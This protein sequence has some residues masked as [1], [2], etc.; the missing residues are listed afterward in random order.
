MNKKGKKKFPLLLVFLALVM[1]IF[2]GGFIALNLPKEVDLGQTSDPEDNLPNPPP[3]EPEYVDITISSVGDILIHNT[4]Y[5]AAYEPATKSYDFRSQFQ[6]VKPYLEKA[7]ITIANLETTLAGPE[8]G[9]SGYPKFNSPDSIIDALK[10]A[11]VDIITA[12]NNHRMDMGISGFY[13]T[14]KIVKDK[15]LDI[16]GVKPKN[17]EKT[18]MLRNVK[19]VN[20]AFLNFSYAYPLG[21]GSLSINGLILPVNMRNLIDIFNPED[22]EESIK[23]LG[24]K[25]TGAREDGAELIVVCMHW[26]DEYHRQPNNFQKELAASI[27]NLGADVVFG[28]H[29]HVLQPAVYLVSP[30]GTKIPVFYS[31]GNFISDQRKET[32]DD[33]YTEQGII[34]QVTFRVPKGEKPQILQVDTIPTWVNKKVIANRFVYEIIPAQK[35]LKS[36]ENFPLLNAA[37]IERINFCVNTVDLLSKEL[38]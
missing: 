33:I 25:I 21:D 24:E 10:D 22:L 36:K 18:Y 30:E 29:P 6:N 13:R 8:K 34:A 38:R 1:F 19:G 26:G 12:A 11:G 4:L 27:V 7:D 5:Y 16:I 32:V 28:G 9:Y 14:I 15:G 31:Q 37:D 20:I 23:A 35:A 2:L 17:E 3:S